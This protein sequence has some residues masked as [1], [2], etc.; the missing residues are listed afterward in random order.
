MSNTWIDQISQQMEHHAVEAPKGLWEG[1]EHELEARSRVRRA[2][3]AWMWRAG[4]AAAVACIALG[5]LMLKHVG[6]DDVVQVAQTDEAKPTLQPTEKMTDAAKPTLQPMEKMMDAANESAAAILA[7][8]T[9]AEP[10]AVEPMPTPP[11]V[12]EWIDSV[13]VP[14]VPQ[15]EAPLLAETTREHEQ[16]ADVQSRDEDDVYRVTKTPA[17]GT[18]LPVPKEQHK[19]RR[20]SM[21]LLAMAS[22]VPSRDARFDN[23][24]MANSPAY[25]LQSDSVTFESQRRANVMGQNRVQRYAY[26]A[27]NYDSHDFPVKVGLTVRVPLGHRVAIDGGLSYARMRSDVNFFTPDYRHYEHGTQFVNYLGVPLSIVVDLWNS[28]RW[29]VYAAGGG[30]AAKSVKST[31]RTNKGSEYSAPASPWQFSVSAAVGAQFNVTERVGIYAQPSADYCFDNHSV[32]RTYYS[33]HPFSPA[34]RVG[35]RINL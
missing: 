15:E 4:A 5:V 11:A 34:L 9:L 22:G 27:P 7:E 8:A 16:T 18:I 23:E 24:V 3:V 32:I 10:S 28:G 12:V 2:R 29:A 33:E 19:P 17:R 6:A 14:S 20:V 13:T 1:I 21:Q 30:E 26:S 31:W 25:G 35:V